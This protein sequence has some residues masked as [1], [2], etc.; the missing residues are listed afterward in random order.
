MVEI[1]KTKK[2]SP[3]AD[4]VRA[5]L[6][7]R[8]RGEFEEMPGLSLTSVQASKLFGISPDV[9]AA[10]T[11]VDGIRKRLGVERQRL[12]V[13]RRA[14]RTPWCFGRLYCWQRTHLA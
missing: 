12:R 2:L 4:L 7:R 14:I 9:C 5:A 13:R 10:A 11:R 1:V 6:A 3:D 8:I